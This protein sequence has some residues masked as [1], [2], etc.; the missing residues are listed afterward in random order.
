MNGSV[1]TVPVQGGVVGNEPVGGR[2][3]TGAAVPAGLEPDRG[4]SDRAAVGGR[5]RLDHLATLRR[6]TT[7]QGVGGLVV[8]HDVATDG[9]AVSHQALRLPTLPASSST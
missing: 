8:Q 9:S 4:G 2:S 6:R 3:R 5:Q 7:K 1:G